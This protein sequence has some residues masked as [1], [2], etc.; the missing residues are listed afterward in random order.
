MIVSVTPRK[1]G[2]SVIKV[3]VLALVAVLISA[4]FY[5]NSLLPIITGYAAKNL[6]SGVFVSGRTQQD[7][8]SHDLNFS[9][10]AKTKNTVDFERMKVTSKFLWGKS[11]A[12]Y[13]DGFGV[14][15][16]RG[17]DE[18]KL[19]AVQF[20]EGVNPGYNGDTIP[21]PMGDIL[22]ELEAD[23]TVAGLQEMAQDIVKTDKYGGDH[24]AALIMHKG[25][26]VAECYDDRFDMNTRFLSWSMAKS[27]TNALIGVKVEQDERIDINRPMKI[28]VWD[29]TKAEKG[30]TLNNLLQMQSGLQWNEDYGNRSDVTVMLHEAYD[31]AE[32]T[33]TREFEHEPGTFWYYSSGTSN[34][35][36]YLLRSI[37][38]SDTD[39]YSF[40]YTELFFRIGITDAVFETDPSG[41][42]V[43]SSYLYMTARDYA[44]F[45]LLYM[46]DGVFC[47][48]RILPEG[49]VD[50]TVSEA[51]ASEGEYGAF[52]WLNRGGNIP[53]A[54]EDMY[55]CVGHDGQRIFILPSQDLAIILLGYSPKGTVDYSV[56]IK[57]ILSKL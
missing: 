43:G 19:R 37:F 18:D 41:T 7:M 22:P 38:E 9:F 29:E 11:V 51:S 56:L 32:Y 24:Y 10:I 45:A 14:T 36:S 33:Y 2:R 28:P 57:D 16:L 49:W 53:G 44:R 25:V 15:L 6:A 5:L 20:P 35:V 4:A 50:Y 12:I 55:M 52:F 23:E 31:F 13:R 1:K 27:F 54:P 26:P 48:E 42:F 40:P 39:Y 3:L 34:F 47:E 46:Q 17:I 30:I 8:E 21:W